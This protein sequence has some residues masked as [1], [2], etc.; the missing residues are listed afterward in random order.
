MVRRSNTSKK[1]TSQATTQ[2]EVHNAEVSTSNNNSGAASNVSNQAQIGQ[3]QTGYGMTQNRFIF[4]QDLVK[5]DGDHG[6]WDR[7]NFEA[8]AQYFDMFGVDILAAEKPETITPEINRNIYLCLVKGVDK[9]SYNLIRH[10]VNNGYEAFHFLDRLINGSRDYRVM[11]V[12]TGQ[13]NLTL[14]DGE[15]LAEYTG[16]VTI[17]VSEG[18]KYGV[19]EQKYQGTY[20]TLITRSLNN[21]PA[22]YNQWAQITYARYSENGF[23]SMSRYLDALT[24]QDRIITGQENRLRSS[25]VHAI[26]NTDTANN[27]RSTSNRNQ[28]RRRKAKRLAN[29]ALESVN[30]IRPTNTQINGSSSSRSGARGGSRG[31]GARS[32]GKPQGRDRVPYSSQGRAPPKQQQQ[33]QQFSKSNITCTRCLSRDGTHDADHCHASKYCSHHDNFSHWTKDC[34]NPPAKR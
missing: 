24:E 16:R 14:E 5:F 9:K 32:G 8:Q 26:N 25:N 13:S 6:S 21:L 2:A 22:R 30:S 27:N 10:H 23:P 3:V 31:R 17:L 29:A 33:Q 4:P 1:A 7:F 11:K 18:E 15:S 28:R 34:R 12:V 20:P 19:G